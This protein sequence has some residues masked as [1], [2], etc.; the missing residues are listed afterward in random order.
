VS[1]ISTFESQTVH[2]MDCKLASSAGVPG[3]KLLR[4]LAQ[5]A[6]N[7]RNVRA[8]HRVYSAVVT[9]CMV[10]SQTRSQQLIMACR[11][12][13]LGAVL[14]LVSDVRALDLTA[15]DK[16]MP[17]VYPHHVSVAYVLHCRSSMAIRPEIMH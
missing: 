15:T 4:K 12:G 11:G 16:V 10:R 6:H 17:P 3:I 7:E 1:E 2:D 14:R 8:L 5:D 9:Q 13:N